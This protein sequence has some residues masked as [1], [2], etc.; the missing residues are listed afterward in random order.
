MTDEQLDLIEKHMF[1][2]GLLSGKYRGSNLHDEIR[3]EAQL[4]LVQA[5]KDYDPGRGTTFKTYARK[6]IGWAIKD[7]FRRWD[8]MT[9]TQRKV[10]KET[11]EV[12]MIR[13]GRRPNPD[14]AMKS[15]PQQPI[16]VG[17]LRKRLW[18]GG[19]L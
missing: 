19:V 10:F 1:L 8:S 2:I 13:R 5:A 4:A 3:D 18:M 12:K 15:D 6:A 11:G 17:A 7:Y 9:R 16:D 14:K